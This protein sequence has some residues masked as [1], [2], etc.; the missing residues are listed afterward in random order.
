[1]NPSDSIVKRFIKTIY[2][3]MTELAMSVNTED[4]CLQDA[5]VLIEGLKA[6]VK[7]QDR[8]IEKLIGALAETTVMLKVLHGI[9]NKPKC[10][11][12]KCAYC[13]RADTNRAVLAEAKGGKV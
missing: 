2:P 7:E 6:K 10:A 3:D 1:M 9:N 4:S 13:L 5:I 8:E 12:V 11:D